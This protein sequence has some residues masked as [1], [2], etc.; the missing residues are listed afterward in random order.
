MLRISL[1]IMCQ[2]RNAD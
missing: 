2:L 1:Y